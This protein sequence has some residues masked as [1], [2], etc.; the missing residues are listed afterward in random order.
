MSRVPWGKTLTSPEGIFKTYFIV[1]FC[2]NYHAPIGCNPCYF[3]EKWNW[4]EKIT[5]LTTYEMVISSD[6]MLKIS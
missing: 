6:K 5:A 2:I 4:L 1:V 3:M